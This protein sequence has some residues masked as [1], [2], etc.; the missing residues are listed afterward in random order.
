[1]AITFDICNSQS[2]ALA[3]FAS[4]NFIEMRVKTALITHHRASIWS[5]AA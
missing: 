3:D 1:M 5:H 4:D 2:D